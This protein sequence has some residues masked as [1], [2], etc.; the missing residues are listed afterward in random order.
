MFFVDAAHFVLGA[1]MSVVWCFAR[2]WIRAPSGK[3]RFNMLGAL[4]AVTQEV[5]TIVDPTTSIHCAS[6]TCLKN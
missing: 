2:G 1:F 6:A 4:D 3:Q 5:V